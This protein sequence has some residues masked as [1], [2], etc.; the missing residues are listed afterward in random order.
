M[1]PPESPKP[2]PGPATIL[3]VL[4]ALESGGVERGTV[5]IAQALVQAGS[6]ALVASAGGRLVGD[7]ARTG[8]RHANVWLNTKNPF[9]IYANI[10]RLENLM[11]AEHIDLVHARSRG[12][13]WSAYF[14]AKRLKIPFVTTWHGV[15]EED[16][17][18]KRFYNSIMT[19][20]EIVIAISHYIESEL[21]RRYKIPKSR[22]RTIHRG[23]DPAKFD[24][25]TISTERIERLRQHWRLPQNVKI[26]M[27][28]AR[29]TRWKGAVTL[30]HAMAKLQTPEKPFLVL[31]GAKQ[32]T[33][34][35]QRELENLADQL[36]LNHHFRIAGHCDDMPAALLLADIIVNASEKP[37]P[38]G[39]TIIE[40]QAMGR[41][42][43]ASDQGGAVETI[44]HGVTGYRVSPG[45]AAALA[46]TITKALTL[47]EEEKTTLTTAARASVCKNFT[48]ASMQRATL[49]VYEELLGKPLVP[50]N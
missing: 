40:A 12:P 42:V 4:P 22:I 13:A 35:Y 10:R 1:S 41:I 23:V 18:F 32:R 11:I 8:A 36:G 28:P 31:V 27:L 20:G 44:E 37:E 34:D 30:L 16:L 50:K 49:A 43:I 48:T 46:A 6:Y 3:Q 47:S 2:P 17:P 45:D 38:F 9:N 15:Y 5:E 39:R 21:I 24:P 26:V 33:P 19:R 7:L 25:A 29:L 14:A